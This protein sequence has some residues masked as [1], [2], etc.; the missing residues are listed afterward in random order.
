MIDLPPVWSEGPDGGKPIERAEAP[1][2]SATGGGPEERR[3]VNGRTRT[4]WARAALWLLILSGMSSARAQS[5]A[6]P[7]PGA[8]PTGRT[9]PAAGTEPLTL[10]QA[11]RI[12]REHNP[13]LLESRSGAES[14]RLTAV[15][16]ERNRL[17]GI[18]LREISLR[19]D[20]PADAFG[21]Q[22]MQERFSFP[23]FQATDP[24]RPAPLNN[25]ATEVEASMPLFTG[26]K[27][28]GGIRQ[29]GRAA[30]AAEAMRDHAGSAVDLAVT[31][32]YLDALLADRYVE[33]AARARETTARHVKMAQDFF[34][35]GMIV[36]SDLLQAQVQLAKMD[37]NLI[38]ARNGAA[39]ARAGLNRAMGIEQDRSFTLTDPGAPP[40]SVAGT[41]GDALDRAMRAREDLAAMDRK[42]DA[43]EAGIGVARSEYWPQIGLSA[44]YS[45]NHDRLFGG[46]GD[47]YTLA[48]MAD[49]RIW[50]WGQTRARVARSR[51]DYNAARESRRSYRDQV[52]FE[53]RA[54]WQ[55]L[56]EARAAREVSQGA[57]RAAERALSI[58]DD[59]FAQG[60]VKMTDLLDAETLAHEA[61]VREVE[62]RF[63]QEKAIRS[64]RFAVGLPLLTEVQP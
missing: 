63:A 20:S 7:V 23:A 40:D 22:L 44:R 8:R 46:H 9:E 15:D 42:V 38:R 11:V 53:V 34:D 57:V 24:N 43:A 30:E 19:T 31:E 59:R 16:A 14:A 47:S 37:E 54:A 36:E 35:S 32:A 2:S 4:G 27:L 13:A 61:R 55:E 18:S 21:L 62:T 41:L 12:A 64:L 28:S 17:P 50:N 45:L 60:L 51:S 58:L 39:L 33:L 49:W 3:D 5:G 29:A 6:L 25:F 1:A 26:G 10:A 48:A 56:E 52:E